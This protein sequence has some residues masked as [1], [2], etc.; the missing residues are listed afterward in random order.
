M[1]EILL[2]G[3]KKYYGANQVLKDIIFQALKE[4]KIEIVGINGTGKA[5]LIKIILYETSAD[6]GEI[7]IGANVK[8]RYLQ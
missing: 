4:E 8:V 7:K 3:I 5:T 2:N 1:I 6:K